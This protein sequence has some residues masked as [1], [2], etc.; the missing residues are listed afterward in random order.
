MDDSSFGNKRK[1]NPSVIGNGYRGNHDPYNFARA[2]KRVPGFYNQMKALTISDM[3]SAFKLESMMSPPGISDEKDRTIE[4]FS[5]LQTLTA[6][7]SDLR[8]FLRCPDVDPVAPPANAGEDLLKINKKFKK[9]TIISLTNVTLTAKGLI[10]L[11]EQAPNLESIDL[12]DCK[13]S[14]ATQAEIEKLKILLGSEQMVGLSVK[15]VKK[16]GLAPKFAELQRKHAA[17]RHDRE[18]P[19]VHFSESTKGDDSPR[20]RSRSDSNASDTSLQVGRAG[21]TGVYPSSSS[22]VLSDHS[23]RGRSPV[24][25]AQY[26]S[27]D[28]VPYDGRHPAACAAASTTAYRGQFHQ[29]R[30]Q[31]PSTSGISS[32]AEQYVRLAAQKYNEGRSQMSQCSVNKKG[33]PPLETVVMVDSNQ[34]PLL[35]SGPAEERVKVC[36]A[37]LNKSMDVEKKAAIILQSLGFP[38]EDP[39]ADYPEQLYFGRNSGKYPEVVDAINRQY[40]AIRERDHDKG[41]D[42][43]VMVKA[44]WASR[45]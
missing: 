8:Y 15:G 11:I 18:N 12:T 21:V 14:K 27:D 19:A 9:L 44:V 2:D 16:V 32:D 42:E 10:E 22:T 43:D 34:K 33:Q 25:T 4:K 1:F 7:N 41:D 17:T 13:F 30:T 39:E 35:K 36:G 6:T 31:G 3:K 38:T 40:A 26:S 37:L 45:H 23:G 29:I 5:N 20:S 28:T 24:R